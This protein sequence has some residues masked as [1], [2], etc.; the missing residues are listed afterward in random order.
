VSTQFQNNESITPIAIAEAPEN[1]P[2]WLLPLEGN[3]FGCTVQYL[4]DNDGSLWICKTAQPII[5]GMSGSPVVSDDGAAIGVV[6]LANASD[7]EDDLGSM[8][9]LLARDLPGWLLRNLKPL[10]KADQR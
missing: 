4:K 5:G 9:P 1:G 6:A 3:W 10:M 8:N 2:A 7:P